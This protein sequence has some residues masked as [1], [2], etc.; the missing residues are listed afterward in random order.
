MA[1]DAIRGCEMLPDAAGESQMLPDA[2]SPDA[3]RYSQMLMLPDAAKCSQMLP[4]DLRCRPNHRRIDPGSVK[5]MSNLFLKQKLTSCSK[6]SLIDPRASTSYHT[7]SKSFVRAL[8]TFRFV[9]LSRPVSPHNSGKCSMPFSPLPP[10]AF[11][12]ESEHILIEIINYKQ[13]R[14]LQEVAKLHSWSM[15]Q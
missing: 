3:A 11:P 14:W 8:V 7:I 5:H 4:H 12:Q 10:A 1:P 2:A 15:V 6:I 13:T 9:F